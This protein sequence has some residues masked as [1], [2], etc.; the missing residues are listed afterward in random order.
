MVPRNNKSVF[1]KPQIVKLK[2]LGKSYSEIV[3]KI[4]SING[5]HHQISESVISFIK[6]FKS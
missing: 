6:L 1:V 2:N 3:S 5:D 4:N